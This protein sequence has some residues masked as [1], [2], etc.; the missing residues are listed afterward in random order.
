[1]DS[2]PRSLLERKSSCTWISW[3]KMGWQKILFAS[4]KAFVDRCYVELD[5]D[6]ART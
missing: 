2:A 1:M 3:K 5:M 4:I 6:I